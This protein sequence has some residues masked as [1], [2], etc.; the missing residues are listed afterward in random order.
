MGGLG[1][2][3]GGVVEWLCGERNITHNHLKIHLTNE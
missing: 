2:G 3:M 1:M